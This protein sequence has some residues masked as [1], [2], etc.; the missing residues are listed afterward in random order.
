MGITIVFNPMWNIS[1]WDII[2]WLKTKGRQKYTRGGSDHILECEA[3]PQEQSYF[4]NECTKNISFKDSWKLTGHRKFDRIQESIWNKSSI[5][6]DYIELRTKLNQF[7]TFV[8]SLIHENN[9]ENCTVIEENSSNRKIC[10]Y[11]K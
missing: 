4:P 5:W 2:V 11:R 9:I 6:I 1:I 8:S 7:E 10:K 3:Q